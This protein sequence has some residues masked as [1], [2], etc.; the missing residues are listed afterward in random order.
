MDDLS[1]Y[2]NGESPRHFIGKVCEEI[3]FQEFWRKGGCVESP[4]VAYLKFGGEWCRLYFDWSNIFWRPAQAAPTAYDA[5][6][7]DS[8]YP[9]VDVAGTHGLRGR[10]LLA[11]NMGLTPKG[12]QVALVFSGSISLIIVNEA[13]VAKY[14]VSGQPA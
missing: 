10:L 6:E 5:P 13:D 8:S 4:N 9:V 12:V 1:D 2:I 7:L 14:T 3:Q 11:I